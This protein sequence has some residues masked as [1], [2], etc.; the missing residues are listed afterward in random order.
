MTTLFPP[1]NGEVL[2][3]DRN[4]AVGIVVN[5]YTAKD[6]RCWIVFSNVRD[7]LRTDVELNYLATLNPP[8]KDGSEESSINCGSIGFHT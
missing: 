5:R 6:G 8:E 3:I 7:Q 4:G 2:K 1:A